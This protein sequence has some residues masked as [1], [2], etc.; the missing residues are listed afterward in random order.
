MDS[1][2]EYSSPGDISR[3]TL[4]NLTER[5]SSVGKSL[6]TLYQAIT[7]KQEPKRWITRI[8]EGHFRK[9]KDTRASDTLSR[10][11]EAFQ[12]RFPDSSQQVLVA[13]GADQFLQKLADSFDSTALE[14]APYEKVE[15]FLASFPD[16]MLESLD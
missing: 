16:T 6:E 15:H 10:M 13:E 11:Q 1:G 5:Y 7:P 4:P 12:R 9:T 8:R 14:R 3:E 2:A